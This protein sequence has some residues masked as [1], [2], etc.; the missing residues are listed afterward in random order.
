[1]EKAGIVLCRRDLR[2]D[3]SDFGRGAN[4]GHILDDVYYLVARNREDRVADIHYY[5][6]GL[7]GQNVS[8]N[9]SLVF[10]CKVSDFA[11]TTCKPA[12]NARTINRL[13]MPLTIHAEPVR[14]RTL[15]A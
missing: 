2:W 10:K 5:L 15:Y 3:F 4:V 6:I 13:N 1:L 9:R 8:R 14:D 12:I 11:G 7:P